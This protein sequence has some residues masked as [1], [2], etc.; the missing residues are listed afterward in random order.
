VVRRLVVAGSLGG[1]GAVVAACVVGLG[2]AVVVGAAVEAVACV[3]PLVGVVTPVVATAVFGFGSFGVGPA[4]AAGACVPESPLTAK[5]TAVPAAPSPASTSATS[6]AAG[7]RRRGCADGTGVSGSVTVADAGA[8]CW[9]SAAP[10]AGRALG[11]LASAAAVS[12]ARSAGA[13]SRSPETA[14][15]A[16]SRCSCSSSIGLSLR[17]GGR[18]VRIQKRRTPKEYTSLSGVAA[19]PDA[20]S[21]EIVLAVP[22]AVPASVS[23]AV[24]PSRATPKSAIF[25]L[26]SESKRT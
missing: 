20:C 8:S 16:A 7:S 9:S 5:A 13:S 11:S 19:S 14:G 18:P 12:A 3:V 23:A 4:V 2:R 6:A 1:A 22:I 17:N 10:S 21:G 25:A 26:P 15:G 24:P